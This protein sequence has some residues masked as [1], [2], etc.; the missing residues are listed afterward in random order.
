MTVFRLMPQLNDDDVIIPLFLLWLLLF[1]DCTFCASS[2]NLSLFDS[3]PSMLCCLLKWER[4]TRGTLILE[5]KLPNGRM[6]NLGVSEAMMGL[7]R[8]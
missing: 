5:S 4:S 3:K 8:F 1:V 2:K 6:E 7:G